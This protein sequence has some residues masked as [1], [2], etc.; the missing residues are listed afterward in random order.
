MEVQEDIDI[1]QN[2][3][4]TEIIEKKCNPD[5]FLSYLISKKG[6]NAADLDIWTMEELKIVVE[7]FKKSLQEKRLS[8]MF[9]DSN[10]KRR[11]DSYDRRNFLPDKRKSE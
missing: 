11:T 2:Y 3:L 4:R 5:E 10:V 9:G 8:K 7:E 6:E 1:K